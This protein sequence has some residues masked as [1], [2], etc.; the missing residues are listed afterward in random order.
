VTTQRVPTQLA[1][2]YRAHHLALLIKAAPAGRS[3][4]STRPITIA[5][6]LLAHGVDLTFPFASPPVEPGSPGETPEHDSEED[7]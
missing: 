2:D 7:A 4:C 5:R 6:Y 3:W 1:D